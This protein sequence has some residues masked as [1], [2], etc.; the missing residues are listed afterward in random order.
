VRVKSLEKRLAKVRSQRNQGRQARRKKPIPTVALVGYT[1]AGKSTLFNT[2]TDSKVYQADKL[3]ATLDP[4]LRRLQ[5]E[6]F[7]EIILADTVGFIQDLPHDLVEA[8]HA[9]LQETVEADLLLHVVDASNPQR[10]E[11]IREVNAVLEMINAEHCPQVLVYNKIDQ[12]KQLAHVDRGD[13]NQISRIWVSA[14]ENDGLSLLHSAMVQFFS[15]SHKT[16]NLQLPPAQG[17]LRA[18]LH[19]HNAVL[20]ESFDA[21]GF[22]QIEARISVELMSRF[23]VYIVTETTTEHE[24][25]NAEILLKS[26]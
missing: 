26:E 1:N 4:T 10:N 8:F 24:Q 13:D 22:W 19:Q 7:D 17:D 9:T 6:G 14:L 2:L 23:E 21:E 25:E 15:E 20:A 18:L 3:F 11:H 5:L 12:I 16:V